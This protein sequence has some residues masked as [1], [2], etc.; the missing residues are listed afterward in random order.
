MDTETLINRHPTLWHMAEVGAWPKIREQ[1]LLSTSALLDLFGYAGE[2]RR[3][4]EAE[5]RLKA[6]QITH[7]D[8]GTALIRDNA[9]LHEQ[10]LLACLEDMSPREWY[11]LLN[12]KV[13]FWVSQE[14]LEGLLN[15]RLYRDREHDVIV[16][17]SRQLTDRP[18]NDGHRFG[19]RV[20]ATGSRSLIRRWRKSRSAPLA[21]RSSAA[22]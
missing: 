4:I 19:A 14:R 7:P 17:D 22:R 15:A 21:V 12:R 16:I 9:P 10:R 8:H 6:V 13:F 2:E 3:R 20:A 1:G 11:T 18:T 5:R